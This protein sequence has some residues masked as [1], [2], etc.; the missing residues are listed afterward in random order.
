MDLREL[1]KLADNEQRKL[2]KLLVKSVGAQIKLRPDVDFSSNGVKVCE[3]KFD[4]EISQN[5]TISA[6]VI[7]YETLSGD[8][9]K[10]FKVSHR[11]ERKKEISFR[12]AESENLP[13][14][15]LLCAIKESEW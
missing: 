6:D 8:I 13:E 9:E 4:I 14:K 15:P 12:M 11:D 3:R 10:E 1:Q 2:Y 5:K 7:M